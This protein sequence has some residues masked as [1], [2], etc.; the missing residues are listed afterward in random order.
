MSTD[1]YVA[2]VEEL[3]ALAVRYR[4]DTEHPD[5]DHFLHDPVALRNAPFLAV[6]SLL[7]GDAIGDRP[8]PE[9]VVTRLWE[10]VWELDADP[11]DVLPQ[12][13]L[14]RAR[15]GRRTRPAAPVRYPLKGGGHG[16]GRGIPGKTEYPAG[17]SDDEAMDLVL[18]VAQSPAGAVEQPDGT[19]RAWGVR[20][21]VELR[22]IVTQLGHLVTAYPVSGKGV[23]T[24]ALD[25]VRAPYVDRLRRLLAATALDDPVRQGLDE[26]MS[27][28]EWDQV[29]QQLRVL[30]T[31][32]KEEL[33]ALAAAAGLRTPD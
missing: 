19:F 26:L 13:V 22:V 4:G 25:E 27:V 14:D 23:V 5:N 31:V 11:E 2:L 10:M 24:N 9:E 33:E 17:W 16:S 18:D 1:A 15:E 7:C 6:T 30:P 3:E 20:D 12:H 8:L 28:G 32:D 21:E 29:L